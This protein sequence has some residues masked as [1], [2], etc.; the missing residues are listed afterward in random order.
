MPEKQIYVKGEALFSSRKNAFTK[1]TVFY[2]KI[3]LTGAMAESADAT[4]LKS[5]GSD[6]VRV[7]PPLAPQNVIA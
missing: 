2:S 3:A 5:V 6:T 1:T 4:D 7:R